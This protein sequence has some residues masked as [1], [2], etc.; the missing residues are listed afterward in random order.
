[1]QVVGDDLRRHREQ[2]FEVG[3]PLAEG[4]QRLPVAPG[5]RCGGSPTRD[6]RAPHRTC[7]SAPPRMR[8]R[9]GAPPVADVGHRARSHASAAG[10]TPARARYA[11]RAP[12]SRRYGYGSAIVHEERIRDRGHALACFRVLVGDRLVRDVAARHHQC[13]RAAEITEQQVVQRR[14]CEHQSEI[15]CARGDAL[16]DRRVRAARHEHDRSRQILQQ[17]GLVRSMYASR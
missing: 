1:M 14:V 7:S 5:R 15:R 8:A 6:E 16:R 11:P 10:A 2:L 17:R 9:G 13:H 12:P 4:A 3:D